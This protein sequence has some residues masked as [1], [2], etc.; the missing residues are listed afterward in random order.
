VTDTRSKSLATD[1]VAKNRPASAA[2]SAGS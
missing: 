2:I 1:T